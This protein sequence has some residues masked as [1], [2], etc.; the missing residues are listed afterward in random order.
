[1][2]EQRA[3][4][5]LKMSQNEFVGFLATVS[6]TTALGIDMVLPAFGQVR[7]AFGLAEDSTQVALTVT[8]YFLGLSLA[9]LIYGPLT[10]RF[11]RKPILLTGL[12][13]YATAA[14]LAGLAPNLP[15]LLAAR[16]LWGIG[17]AG[18][19]VLTM[20]IARDVYSGDRL[21]RVLSL[22]QALF[23]IAPAV[24]PLLGQAVLSTGNWRL[25]FIVPALPA[26][27]LMV[28]SA[29]LTETLKP[30]DRRPLTFDQT[31][32]AFK[33]V[34]GNRIALGFSLAVMFD[35]A[36]FSS[37]L[38]SSELLFDR[39]YDRS[40]Q[41]PLAFGL[42]SLVMGLTAFSGSRLVSRLGAQ[43][44]IMTAIKFQLVFI[45]ALMAVS[46]AGGGS[47]PF[48]VWFALVALSNAIRTVVNPL[49]VSEAMQPMGELAGTAASVMGTISM[50]G[51]ALLS[52]VTDRL[53]GD[54]VT[55]L[56]SAYLFY[57]VLQFVA[58]LWATGR[59]GPSRL[60]TTRSLP[61][62]A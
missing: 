30:E 57:G 53:L 58:L 10:D 16:L 3:N 20:A 49:S 45:L 5:R 44:I 2:T 4:A 13:L 28:W 51:G 40:S 15:L 50:G 12:A 59:I 60:A 7:Q 37:F 32:A 26:V 27:A 19:R 31:A 6:A 61:G 55:P 47:P 35:F 18:P 29:R 46:V 9:Q 34:V 8:V 24:A 22:A 25:V 14:V 52:I 54:S 11:G 43:P 39:V 48:F 56:S 21:G 23:M 1:M 17:A 62:Q 38:S 41:F 42:M 33:A 36:A